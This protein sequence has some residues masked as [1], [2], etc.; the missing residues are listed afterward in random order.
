[1]PLRL[2]TP[3]RHPGCGRAVRGGYC[4]EHQGAKRQFDRGRGSAAQRGYDRQWERVADE[5]RRMDFHLCQEC[6]KHDRLTTSSTVD[7][8]VPIY[9]RPDW[10]LEI[11]NAQVLCHT[12]HAAKT[13]EDLRMYGGRTQRSFTSEQANNRSIAM[14]LTCPPR[15]NDGTG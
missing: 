7:H 11:D 8:I 12:C 9:V 15:S 10:R 3:C 14:K 1:M 6:L 2:K 4:D 13:R 5:R